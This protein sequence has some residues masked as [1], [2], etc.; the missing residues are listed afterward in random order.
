M[1]GLAGAV[2]LVT[3]CYLP[4]PVAAS[5]AGTT[6]PEPA[7]PDSAWTPVAGCAASLQQEVLERVN[8]LRSRHGLEPLRAHP[9][10]VGAAQSHSVDQARMNRMTHAG[11]DASTVAARVQ[12]HG[13]GFA[14]VA[15]NV[16]GGHPTAEA[17]VEGWRTSRLHRELM[18][19]P[20]AA[21]AG[22]GYAFRSSGRLHHFW[23]LVLADASAAET[24]PPLRCHP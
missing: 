12:R 20:D 4:Y 23:T 5:R 24:T 10:L 7:S 6:E 19:S 11:S 13:Y 18:L 16:A 1:G 9:E 14:M 3:G 2:A 17:V 15:E 22:L 8:R 21:Q